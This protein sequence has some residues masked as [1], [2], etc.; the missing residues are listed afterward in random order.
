MSNEHERQ[1]AERLETGAE[2]DELL[3]LAARLRRAGAATQATPSLDFQ[4]QLRRDLLNQ[5]AT[6]P[7]QG[8]S[9]W[10]WAGSLAAVALLAVVVG[11]T[12]L[13]MSSTGRLTFGGSPPPAYQLLEHTVSVT[14]PP[15]GAANPPG[16]AL[17]PDVILV[18]DTRWSL[19][20]EAG[21]V[22]AFVHLLD[23]NDQVIAQADVPLQPVTEATA[24]G[25]ATATASLTVTADM[26]ANATELVAGL[27]DSSTGAR[28][29]LGSDGQTTARL[30][31]VPVAQPSEAEGSDVATEPS[32]TATPLPSDYTLL[33]Y[34]ITGGIVT[35]S[36]QTDEGEAQTQSLLIPGMVLEVVTRWIVPLDSG[37][38]Q[39]FV[40]LAASD[41]ALVAQTNTSIQPGTGADD[42]PYEV[43]L[44]LTLPTDLAPGAYQLISGLY[45]PTTGAQLSFNTAEGTTI[46]FVLGE[47][48]VSDSNDADLP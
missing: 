25:Q 44:S 3:A 40:H 37:E 5:Y 19:P 16:G 36:M 24:E 31:E 18:V 6:T 28:L 15:D 12:W 4:R 11:L 20:P 1:W 17:S 45:D 30:G 35:E 34:S 22:V 26:A 23:A 32:V 7:K 33:D 2:D 13:S 10:R 38:V 48:V 8:A 46:M 27:Y 41:K 21:D 9:I 39:A 29:P 47:Y 14:A 42:Q 43:V